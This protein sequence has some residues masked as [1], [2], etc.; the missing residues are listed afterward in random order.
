MT[1]LSGR[2]T[3]R[4]L[5]DTDI[6]ESH[7]GG[8]VTR[9]VIRIKRSEVT[10]AQHRPLDPFDGRGAVGLAK[11]NQPLEDRQGFR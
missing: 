4:A 10:C 11:A 5:S 8:G 2:P 6:L 1:A 3:I 9:K 7:F